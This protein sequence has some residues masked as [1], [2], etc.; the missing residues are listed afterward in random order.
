[1]AE[2][3]AERKPFSR[4]G[5]VAEVST[6]RVGAGLAA[7][8]GRVGGDWEWSLVVLRERDLGVSKGPARWFSL[9]STFSMTTPNE[10]FSF[11][12]CCDVDAIS[13]CVFVKDRWSPSLAKW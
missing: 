8:M 4:S 5:S 2:A 7:G 1:M 10:D 9:V 13:K 11:K 12:S 6:R 3:G